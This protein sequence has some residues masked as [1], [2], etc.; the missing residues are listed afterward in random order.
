MQVALAGD[1]KVQ[2]SRINASAP[3]WNAVRPDAVASYFSNVRVSLNYQSRGPAGSGS[4][5]K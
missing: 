5:I 4:R 3:G 2:K 1:M